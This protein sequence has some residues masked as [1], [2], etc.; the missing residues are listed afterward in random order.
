MNRRARRI[1]AAVLAV[2]AMTAMA[3]CSH[4]ASEW[5]DQTYLIAGGSSTGVY[6]DYGGRVADTL[7]DALGVSMQVEQTAGSIDNLRRVG[8]GEALLGFAQADAAAD[9]E[10]GSGEFDEP[11]PIVAIARLYDEYL[12]V[13]VR[14]D[15]DIAAITDLPGATVSLGAP[16]SGVNV[17]AT[18]VLA[19]AGVDIDDVDDP[20][21]G[22]SDS[23]EAMQAGE[24][25]G[26]FWVGG[27]PTPGIEELAATQSVRLLPIERTWVTAINEQYA[28][29]YR[30]AD[31]P[32]GTYGLTASAPTM[33]VPNYLV[34]RAS[35]SDAVVRDILTTLFDS[36][37]TLA[38][39]VP[40]AALLDRRQA[41]FTSPVDLH[42]GAIA[43]YRDKRD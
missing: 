27:L 39:E 16:D 22:L 15:S 36:R 35:A 33:A 31:L 41:I 19:A 14:G 2:V 20:H 18:R 11:L 38:A 30:S 3:G 29:A 32:V 1:V 43:Y 25:D 9:A 34:T 4:R 5:D 23:I 17:I 28:N 10:M 24:I 40:A 8:S 12:H 7:S 21:L 42:P 37:Q 13:V 6:Y 26:F